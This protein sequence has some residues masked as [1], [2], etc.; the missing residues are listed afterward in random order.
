MRFR[1]AFLAFCVG[2]FILATLSTAGA[3][4]TGTEVIVD[5]TGA[6]RFTLTDISQEYVAYGHSADGTPEGSD[7]YLY[8]I[9]SG[10][11]RAVADEDWGEAAPVL[12]GEYVYYRQDP[13]SDG[14]YS[15]GRRDIDSDYTASG[16]GTREGVLSF[17][18]NDGVVVYSHDDDDD[19]VHDLEFIEPGETAT[20]LPVSRPDRDE[21]LPRIWKD[22]VVW[23]SRTA[24]G[25]IEAMFYHLDYDAWGPLLSRD[26]G[27]ADP[28]EYCPTV[29]GEWAVWVEETADRTRVVAH[30]MITDERVEVERADV[31]VTNPEVSCDRLFFT[32]IGG[33]DPYRIMVRDLVSGDERLVWSPSDGGRLQ[34]NGVVRWTASYGGNVAW[35]DLDGTLDTDVHAR[36]LVGPIDLEQLEGPDRYDTGVAISQAGFPEGATL[37]VVATGEDFPD[38]LAASFFGWR[39]PILLTRR[40]SLPPATAGELQ[41]LDPTIVY[42]IGGAGAVS[43]TVFAAILAA[44]PGA[45]VIR[46]EGSDRYGTARAVLEQ[47]HAYVP[48]AF[49]AT[50]A[51]FPDALAASPLAVSQT[52]PI[53]LAE[54]AGI[55]PTTIALMQAH[56]I[57]DVYM[58]GG[59]SVVGGV[60]ESRLNTAFGPEHVHRL[61]GDTRYETALEIAKWA[62]ENRTFAEWSGVTLATGENFPDALTG[63]VLAGRRGTVMLLTHTASLTPSVRSEL[64]RHVGET[65]R[66]TF[67][68]GDGAISESVIDSVENAIE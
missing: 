59:T 29:W 40:D 24:A 25:D 38:A 2:C 61:Y 27:L 3:G 10:E 7:I 65:F 47:S 12:D 35:W 5:K 33:G 16:F 44:V 62:T 28:D 68:G 54:P 26:S 9:S 22:L 48:Y 63:G 23:Q 19:G 51:D 66:T 20:D 14:E 6:G 11:E 37:A 52:M 39:G 21:T 8:D 43:D 41:R 42:V 60:T 1:T 34:I 45:D 57:E 4:I 56:G 64:E 30:N 18:V 58:V 53:L 67:F 31:Y 46:V 17:D 50:G 32:L 36:R 49:V 13:D 15:I 55:S